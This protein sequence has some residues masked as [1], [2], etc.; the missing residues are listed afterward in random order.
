[1]SGAYRQEYGETE[2][3]AAV[4]AAIATFQEAEGRR[5]RILVAK[6]GQVCSWL[7]ALKKALYHLCDRT[8]TTAGPR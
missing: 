5:P 8:A 3:I 4:A 1:M 2:E 6:M 7:N